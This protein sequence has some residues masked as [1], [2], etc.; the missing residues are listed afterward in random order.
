MPASFLSLP[1][2]LRSE[3]YKHLLVRRE[4]IDPWSGNHEL[5]LNLLSTNK[6]SLHEAGSIFYGRNCCTLLGNLAVYLYFLLQLVLS[7]HLTFSV[8]ASTFLNF[9]ILKTRPA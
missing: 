2:K 6:A 4:P 9:A 5:E 3:I 1:A 8:S 7:T